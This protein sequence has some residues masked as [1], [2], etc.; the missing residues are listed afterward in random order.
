[1]SK[2]YQFAN[3]YVFAARSFVTYLER[4]FVHSAKSN[5]LCI[6]FV[7]FIFLLMICII[8]VNQLLFLALNQFFNPFL[9]Y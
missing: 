7:G 3:E 4:S 5:Q 9:Y 1:M 6:V 2:H 8:I